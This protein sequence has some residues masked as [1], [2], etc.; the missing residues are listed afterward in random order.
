MNV[1]ITVYHS[2]LSFEWEIKIDG[3]QIASGTALHH[4]DAVSAS[5]AA[6]DAFKAGLA[7]GRN[8]NNESVPGRQRV[9]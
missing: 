5:K 4:D 1:E 2:F 3:D 6:M 8:A 7:M 9:R